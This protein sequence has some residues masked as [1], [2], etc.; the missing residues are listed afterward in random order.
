MPSFPLPGPSQAYRRHRLHPPRAA[1]QWPALVAV[2]RLRVD[3]RTSQLYSFFTI[4]CLISSISQ[5]IYHGNYLMSTNSLNIKTF[6]EKTS[7]RE[8]CPGCHAEGNE[9]S[10]CPSR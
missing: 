5:E 9:V 3:H 2:C 6:G 8:R 1:F 4:P 7:P 10:L